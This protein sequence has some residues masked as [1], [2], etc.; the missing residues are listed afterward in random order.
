MTDC[1]L[2]LRH[3]PSLLLLAVLTLA[4][5]CWKKEPLGQAIG[6]STQPSPPQTEI[7]Q[8]EDAVKNTQKPQETDTKKIALN[9][10]VIE[11]TIKTEEI[12]INR[13][14][15]KGQVDE[16]RKEIKTEKKVVKQAGREQKKPLTANSSVLFRLGSLASWELHKFS[17]VFRLEE[18]IFPDKISFIHNTDCLNAGWEQVRQSVINGLHQLLAKQPQKGINKESLEAIFKDKLARKH[19]LDA[20]QLRGYLTCLGSFK[21]LMESLLEATTPKSMKDSTKK[22]GAI[23]TLIIEALTTWCYLEAVFHKASSTLP[24]NKAL[25]QQWLEPLSLFIKGKLDFEGKEADYYVIKS[26]KLQKRTSKDP[27]KILHKEAVGEAIGKMQKDIDN[28][29]HIQVPCYIEK[30]KREIEEEKR[31][32]AWRNGH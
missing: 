30:A 7:P 31:R 3:T 10:K 2:F 11:N 32:N 24:Y 16:D 27:S 4:T 14:I 17:N 13:N 8:N 28:F 25:P 21:K 20:C 6:V 9:N 19:N 26:K 15:G 29:F 5:G 1:N 18:D 22:N 12:D 23:M